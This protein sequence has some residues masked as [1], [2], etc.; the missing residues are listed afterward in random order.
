MR[1]AFTAAFGLAAIILPVRQSQAFV[2]DWIF[3]GAGDYAGT[4][5]PWNDEGIPDELSVEWRSGTGII[6]GEANVGSRE[7]AGTRLSDGWFRLDRTV[8]PSDAG[9]KESTIC[10]HRR[11]FEASV[12]SI[13]YVSCSSAR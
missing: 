8:R 5:L 1:L 13:V 4:E 6:R 7:S 9:E 11:R 3:I 10:F 2:P 12:R